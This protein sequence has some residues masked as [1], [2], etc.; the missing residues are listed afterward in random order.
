MEQ[1][2]KLCV[3]KKI[4]TEEERGQLRDMDDVKVDSELPYRERVHEFIQ[5]IGNPYRYTDQGFIVELTFTGGCSF[6]ER[7]T[8]YLKARSKN[9]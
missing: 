1:E 5:Q 3:D 2:M 8:E 4:G 6:E 7:L 9:F